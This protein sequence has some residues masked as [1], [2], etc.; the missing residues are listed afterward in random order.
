MTKT[1]NGKEKRESL[2]RKISSI[3]TGVIFVLALA[4]IIS[5]TLQSIGG[6]TP[7]LLG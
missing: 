2:F 6:K 4:A 5:L 3:V 7:S 1:D